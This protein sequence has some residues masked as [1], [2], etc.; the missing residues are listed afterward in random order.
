MNPTCRIKTCLPLI[1]LSFFMAGVVAEEVE[2]DLDGGIIEDAVAEKVWDGT[3]AFGL[4]GKTGNSENLDI[5]MN[6]NMTR[7][8]GPSSTKVQL[9]YFYA[10]NDISTTTDRLYALGRHEHDFENH[11][12]LSCFVQSTYEYDRF[13]DFDYQL[14]LHSGLSYK[15]YETEIGFLKSRFGLGASR[16]FGGVD[17]DWKPEL[18][19]GADCEKKLSERSK[20]FASVDYFPNVSDFADHRVVTN[21]GFEFVIDDELNLNFRIFV[22]DRFDSTPEP[23]NQKNDVDYGMAIVYGF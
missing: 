3:F 2:Y 19:F 18:Q 12:R 22:L 20:L 7:D 14:G 6:M 10:S 23:G 9:S 11:P 16:Q 15:W 13:K 1:I 17:D 5:N 8:V 4:N 21:G